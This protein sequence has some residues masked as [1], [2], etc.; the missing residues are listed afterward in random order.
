MDFKLEFMTAAMRLQKTQPLRRVV[1][2]VVAQNSI[3]AKLDIVSL[4]GAVDS[5]GG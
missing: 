5:K 3:L 1:Q 4:Q 2:E